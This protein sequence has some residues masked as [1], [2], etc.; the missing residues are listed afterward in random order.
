MSPAANDPIAVD[1]NN[2][3]DVGPDDPTKVGAAIAFP[4]QNGCAGPTTGPA[5]SG[6]VIRRS[7][8]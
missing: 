1:E 3:D 8:R 6:K 4:F 5:L 7:R 2:P